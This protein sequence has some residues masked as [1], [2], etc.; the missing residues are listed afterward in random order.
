MGEKKVIDF[1]PFSK[2]EV[3]QL[4][5]LKPQCISPSI[6]HADKVLK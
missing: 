6:I 2:E 3:I 1:T 4:A 5:L